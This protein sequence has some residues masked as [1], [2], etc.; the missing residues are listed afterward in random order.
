MSG[1]SGS[2]GAAE[3]T[4]R[5]Q[6]AA[7]ARVISSHGHNDLTLG[8]VSVRGEDGSTMWIKRKGVALSEVAADDVIASDL[9]GTEAPGGEGMHLE[10]VM[11]SETYRRNR[12]VNAV[13]HT[14]PSF[15]V[16][17]GASGSPLLMV[18]HDS[19]LFHDGIGIYDATSGLITTRELAH[20]VVDALGPHR[21]VLLVHHGVLIAGDDIRWAVLAAINLEKAIGAQVTAAILGTP[22]EIPADEAE[23]VF[24][25]KYQDRFFDEYWDAWC[26]E[27]ERQGYTP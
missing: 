5:R 27:L 1:L 16:A 21:A 22:K 13:I 12:H 25:E 6:V 14:H 26:R 23:G 2:V 3:P 8:H 17:L 18:S 15:A 20:G 7:A 9:S 4:A 24:K 19:I 10:A 11:H